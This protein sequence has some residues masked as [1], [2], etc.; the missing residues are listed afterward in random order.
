MLE[1]S[2]RP[3]HHGVAYLC[4]IAVILAATFA[5]SPAQ[6]Q[7]ATVIPGQRVSP[8]QRNTISF[9]QCITPTQTVSL[10][11]PPSLT[12]PSN[13]GSTVTPSGPQPQAFLSQQSPTASAS[14]AGIPYTNWY[15]P[16]T[17]GAVGP[18]HIAAATNGEIR[19]QSRTGT[20]LRATT[21]QCFFG[22]A[23]TF[24][25]RLVYDTLAGR[26]VVIAAADRE[27]TNS[28][29]RIG[30]SQ[31]S[32]PLGAWFVYAF[33][34][35]PG[36]NQLWVDQPRLGFNK[37]WIAVQANMYGI[38]GIFTGFRS[39]VWA[40][41][42]A[43]LYANGSGAHTL[44]KLT[45]GDSQTPALTYDNALATLYMLEDY[46][47]G[48]LRL[49]SIG[50][51]IGSETVTIGPIIAPS[52]SWAEGMSQGAPQLGSSA[53]IDPGDARMNSLVYRNGS[54]W[55][56][57]TVFLPPSNPTRSAAQ[58]IQLTPSG[59][60][61]QFGRIDDPTGVNYYAYPSITVNKY[62]DVLI[63]YSRFSA[64][65]YASA[66]Y[67]YR[68]ANDPANA[69]R[70]EIVSKAGQGPY[71]DD[72]WGDYSG[73]AVDPVGDTA[74]WT[75]QEYAATNNQWGTWW[76]KVLAEGPCNY[77]PT[78]QLCTFDTRSMGTLANGT[79]VE[80][81]T[82]YGRAFNFDANN[83]PWPNNGRDL[84]AVSQYAN[85]PCAFAPANQPCTFDTRT[86]ARMANNT[87]VESITAY[88]RAFNFD[89]NGV[90]WPNNG[91][92]L[93][94]VSRFANGPCAFAP[95]NQPCTF[96]TRSMGTL[97]N[98]T[99]VESITAYG[100]AF[101]FDANGVAWPNNGRSLRDVSQY[102]S[103][104]CAFAPAN[105]PCTFDTRTLARMANNTWVESITAYGRAFN[106]DA[107]GVAWPNNG[108]DL[109]TVSRFLR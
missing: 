106:F 3:I 18:S 107:N 65:Q 59:A 78:G 5:Q 86:L 6:V 9:G 32:D 94:T 15:P 67:A 12:T 102:A 81:I 22:R 26:W 101:N 99:W 50:G 35:D 98:G 89:A 76:V 62:N 31:T 96:D 47:G 24:D 66:N 27:S 63:G 88:G 33:A 49:S 54:L 2:R 60:I 61:Q 75:I 52:S 80:S 8:I 84:R 64:T 10:Y 1:I 104:P 45:S 87:W 19:V 42:K 92:D 48:Q 93:R 73:A 103:G 72:R 13:P 79:W 85:G 108:G 14:F 46:A 55:A 29:M 44:V 109:R 36:I 53:R 43:D 41:N 7:A 51:S 16:D 40:L 100:R 77:A 58:W 30:V 20:T 17:Q 74:L 21:L 90:A 69:T 37:T 70:G 23:D 38:P 97:A 82:A 83:T 71:T 95:A 57:H 34:A 56:A 28:T 4:A 25:P 91:G 39:Q 11:T 68:F 105:Q